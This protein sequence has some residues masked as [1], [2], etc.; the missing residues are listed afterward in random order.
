M[1]FHLILICLLSLVQTF[2][3]EYQYPDIEYQDSDSD[4]I[5]P[6]IS[7]HYKEAPAP[8]IAKETGKIASNGTIKSPS[9]LED[10]LQANLLQ[11]LQANLL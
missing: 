7:E 4:M 10:W 11:W 2:D 8:V 1:M 5:P 3:Y 9:S 6:E